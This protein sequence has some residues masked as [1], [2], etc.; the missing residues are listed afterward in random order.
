MPDDVASSK[1]VAKMAR[2]AWEAAAVV[3]ALDETL[4]FWVVIDAMFS[5]LITNFNLYIST[6]DVSENVIFE[7]F[8]PMFN[9]QPFAK[10][11]PLM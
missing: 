10:T 3:T 2:A 5:I 8:T 7:E 11:R 9:S 4:E 1:K 6:I